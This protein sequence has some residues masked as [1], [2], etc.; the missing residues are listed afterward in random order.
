[1]NCL[2]ENP[3]SSNT[4]RNCGICCQ[5]FPFVEVNDA[6]MTVL[7]KFTQM[8]RKEFTDPIGSNYDAGHFLKFK[9]NGDCMFL[10]ADNGFFSCTVYEARAGICR[11][12]PVNKH[13]WKWCNENRVKTL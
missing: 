7:E 11:N 6:E 13:H 10:K 3:V 4:C 9:E 8:D 1:M 2:M 12:Y 5:N